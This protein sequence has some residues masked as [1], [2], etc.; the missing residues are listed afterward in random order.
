MVWEK[1]EVKTGGELEMRNILRCL[2]EMKTKEMEAEGSMG[3]PPCL[4][5]GEG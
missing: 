5:R 3:S 4:A 2:H 1:E